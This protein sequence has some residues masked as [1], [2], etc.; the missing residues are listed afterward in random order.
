MDDIDTQIAEIRAFNRFHTRLVGALNEGLLASDFPLVQVRVLYDLAHAGNLAAADLVARLGVDAGYMSRMISALESRGLIEKTPDS[1]NA[2]RL[3]LSLSPEGRAV[4]ER[5]NRASAEE[6]RQ[7]ISPLS[8]DERRQ[9]VGAMQ[10]IRR[11]LGDDALSTSI[12]PSDPA[13][14]TPSTERRFALRDPR[15]GDL[16]FVV[17]RQAAIY[18]AEYGWDWSYEALVTRIV[19][20]FVTRFD[21]AS[22]RCWIAE[23]DGAIAGSV[24]VVRQDDTTAKLRLLYVEASARGMGLGRALVDEVIRFA[25]ERGYTRLELWTNSILVSARRIYQAAGFELID[26]QPHVSFGHDLVGQTWALE[27]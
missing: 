14:A 8:D 20:D 26:E 4:F 21:P 12:G 24:F 22:D 15:P 1:D 18:A 25:R 11:L 19:S 5:L 23:I 16:G 3:V 27:L 10:T 7:L 6:V 2:K 9:L 17:H 13:S